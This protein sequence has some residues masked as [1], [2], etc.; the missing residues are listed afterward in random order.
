MR[1]LLPVI[2]QGSLDAELYQLDLSLFGGE[3]AVAMAPYVTDGITE[4]FSFAYY[5]YF[6]FLL[7]HLIPL[8][9]TTN[10]QRARAELTLGLTIVFCSGQALYMV[11]PGYGPGV[12]L[13]HLFDSPLPVG[14]FGQL[15]KDTVD[16]W[17]AQ[18]DIFP[19]IHTAV[20]TLLCL[21]SFRFRNARLFSDTGLLRFFYRS[22]LGT[23][24]L[25]RV[26]ILTT[27]FSL[28]VMV[29]TM[30]LRWH[31][32]IDVLAGLLL[33]IAGFWLSL[34]LGEREIAARKSRG[35]SPLWPYFSK[36]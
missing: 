22:P 3:P 16:R 35:Y 32:L 17:G 10:H 9:I 21:W 23:K 33:G 24:F 4:W 14:F 5:G 11:V 8:V 30:Y 34:R 2:N 15:V 1:F 36:T 26:W 13:P 19:S 6:I 12:G 25:N 28:N 29:A 20:P 31:Y 7:L 18:K 27:L